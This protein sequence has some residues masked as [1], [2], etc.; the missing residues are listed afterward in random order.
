MTRKEAQH[1][2]KIH[3][4]KWHNEQRRGAWLLLDMGERRI[5]NDYLKG[6][7]EIHTAW[8]YNSDDVQY[9]AVCKLHTSG[10]MANPP[11]ATEL[12]LEHREPIHVFPSDE[13]ITK[14][15]MVAG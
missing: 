10:I 12:I 14:I 3:S 8:E 6:P 4:S 13:L 2:N 7:Y 11:A 9:M 5:R 15:I 1:H